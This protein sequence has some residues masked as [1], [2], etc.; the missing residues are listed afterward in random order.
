MKSQQKKPLP[1]K[2][3]ASHKKTEAVVRDKIL[4]HDEVRFLLD[5]ITDG[6]IAVDR[7]WNYTFVNDEA[8]HLSQDTKEDLMGKN[9]LKVHRDF[10][11]SVFYEI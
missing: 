1:R 4:F 7:N 11:K 2:K 5:G 8:A 3:N 10:H 6:V 9:M